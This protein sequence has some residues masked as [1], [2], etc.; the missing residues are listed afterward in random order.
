MIVLINLKCYYLY[1]YSHYS[2]KDYYYWWY[3]Y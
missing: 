2:S 3:C 1:L